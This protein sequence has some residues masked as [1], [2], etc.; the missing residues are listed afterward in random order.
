MNLE[1]KP[2]GAFEISPLRQNQPPAK[3][4]I[5]MLREIEYAE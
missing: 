3:A 4:R 1:P 5:G 2:I